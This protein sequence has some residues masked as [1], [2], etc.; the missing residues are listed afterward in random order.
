[1]LLVWGAFW[2]KGEAGRWFD[3]KGRS[4]SKWDEMKK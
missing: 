2:K 4:S 1:M 3:E